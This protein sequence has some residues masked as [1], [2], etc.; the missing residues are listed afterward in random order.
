MHPPQKIGI[1][2]LSLIKEVLDIPE[3]ESLS[4]PNA[5]SRVIDMNKLYSSAPDGNNRSLQEDFG[6]EVYFF[7]VEQAY[8][9]FKFPKKNKAP[10]GHYERVERKVN[11]FLYVRGDRPS[12]IPGA[13]L[14]NASEATGIE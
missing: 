14:V 10:E 3:V 6:R 13:V 4:G 9:D 2:N 12:G 5:G 11:E 1:T 8:P 7:D